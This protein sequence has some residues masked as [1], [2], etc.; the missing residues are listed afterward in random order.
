[1]SILSLGS[2][3]QT[4]TMVGQALGLTAGVS[5]GSILPGSTTFTNFTSMTIPTGPGPASLYP[6][7]ITVA[8]MQGAVTKVVAAIY[9][10][11][12]TWSPEV[13]VMLVS[14]QLSK[15]V[16][17][18]SDCGID[19]LPGCI[20]SNLD[21]VFDMGAANF[22][23]SAS[24]LTSGTYKPT[25]LTRSAFP[26]FPFP[27][28]A[29]QSMVWPV[30]LAVFNGIDPNGVWS[31]YVRDDVGGDGGSLTGGW[32]LTITASV[33]PGGAVLDTAVVLTTESNRNLTTEGALDWWK[34]G[35]TAG[36][37]DTT[38]KDTTPRLIHGAYTLSAPFSGEKTVAST[39]QWS[40]GMPIA[41]GSG[42][43]R[44]LSCAQSI[45]AGWTVSADVGNTQKTFTLYLS[46]YSCTATI[47]THISDAST[48]D[49]TDTIV[50]ALNTE[51]PGKLVVTVKGTNAAAV[52]TV[53]VAMSAVSGATP[54]V[55]LIASTLA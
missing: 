4:E 52:L 43:A 13:E 35:V 29:P 32:S 17:L 49:S 34:Y 54:Y 12:H 20:V 31:L 36:L 22:M 26:D 5:L 10:L 18:M 8:N 14:P 33:T 25:N 39:F 7:N 44:A 2:I 41:T 11:S 30:D 53:T 40:A 45:N 50:A 23:P 48:A 46:V 37:Y 47:T 42:V 28:P 21:L 55:A 38:A 19:A 27:L 6:S 51:V 9:H 24:A 15:Y 3:T 1:M 16:V